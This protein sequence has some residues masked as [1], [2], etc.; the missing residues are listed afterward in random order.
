MESGNFFKDSIMDY[1]DLPNGT[2]FIESGQLYVITKNWSH[3]IC[4]WTPLM[5]FTVVFRPV[6]SGL[7]FR[8]GTMPKENIILN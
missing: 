1:A 5:D 6:D 8:N 4:V 7:T 2:Q 3:F